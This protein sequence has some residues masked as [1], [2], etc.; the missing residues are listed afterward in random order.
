MRS[1]ALTM[2]QAEGNVPALDARLDQ[3]V[4]VLRDRAAAGIDDEIL[5]VGH[6]SGAIMAASVIARASLLDPR[7]ALHGP[8]ISMLILGQWLPLLGTLPPAVAF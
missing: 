1:N 6:L 4:Q 8:R 2:R 7:L 5:V 3:H